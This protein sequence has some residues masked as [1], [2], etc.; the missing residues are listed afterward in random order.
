MKINFGLTPD[1][2]QEALITAQNPR[3]VF[4]DV[5]VSEP[6]VIDEGVR[7]TSVQLT[8]TG[9]GVYAVDQSVAVKYTRRD[10]AGLDITK[11]DREVILSA[12]LEG[13]AASIEAAVL[14]ELLLD[15]GATDYV[16]ATYDEAAGTVT[17]VPTSDATVCLIG[18]VVAEVMFDEPA[19]VLADDLDVTDLD[20]FSAE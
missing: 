18:T 14:S 19:A 5:S 2:N 13:N 10:I 11:A 6:S 9:T 17:I 12:E 16:T 1:A 8:G 7:N 3:L 15:E 4:A 20:G